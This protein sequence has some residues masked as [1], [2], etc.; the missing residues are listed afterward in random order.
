M[1]QKYDRLYLVDQFE[2]LGLDNTNARK[3]AEVATGVREELEDMMT[4]VQ[5]DISSKMTESQNHLLQKVGVS[6]TSSLRVWK[7]ACK[8]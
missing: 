8:R 1:K 7:N 3:A 6:L 5:R 4:D 2:L